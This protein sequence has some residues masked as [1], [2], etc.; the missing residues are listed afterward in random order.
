MKQQPWSSFQVKLFCS[1]SILT[2]DDQAPVFITSE[3][4]VSP[5]EGYPSAL[6]TPHQQED[7]S[8]ILQICTAYW[9]S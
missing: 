3:P 7:L 6:I 1:S 4:A 5:P 9:R 2:S 8:Q